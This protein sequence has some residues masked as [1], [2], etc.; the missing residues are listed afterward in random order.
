MKFYSVELIIHQA[1]KAFR[2]FPMAMICAILSAALMIF[3][4]DESMSLEKNV[5][6][7][8]TLQT[9]WLGMVAYVGLS[10]FT[11]RYTMRNSTVIL[12]NVAIAALMVY[13]FFA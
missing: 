5:E 2:R 13:Y 1:A 6:W 7:F 11:Q 12:L 3:M 8:Y 10:V 4:I 9:L